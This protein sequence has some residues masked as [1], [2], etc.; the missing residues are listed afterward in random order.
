MLL[1]VHQCFLMALSR[2]I[3]VFKQFYRQPTIFLYFNFKSLK[4]ETKICSQVNWQHVWMLCKRSS[5]SIISKLIFHLLTSCSESCSHRC[6]SG[7]N[8]KKLFYKYSNC[9]M[10]RGIRLAKALPRCFYYQPPYPDKM[11]ITLC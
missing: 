3:I 1:I 4:C 5:G 8:A 6:T 9:E 7:R 2:K 11:A 10:R